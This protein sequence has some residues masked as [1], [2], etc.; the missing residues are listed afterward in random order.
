MCLDEGLGSFETATAFNNLALNISL[1]GPGK[2]L[3]IHRAGIEFAQHR[4]LVDTAMWMRGATLW[5]LFELG[6]WDELVEEGRHLLEWDESVGGGLIGVGVS[7]CIAQVSLFRGHLAE[8]RSLE[9]GF[10][11]RARHALDAQTLA[12]A[13]AIA[14]LIERATDQLPEAVRLS[15]EYGEVTR[16]DP[17]NRVWSLLRVMPVLVSAGLTQRAESLATVD[18]GA[19]CTPRHLNPLVTARA[20]LE[21]ARGNIGEASELYSQAV[22]RWTDFGFV[23][24]RGQ[25]LLGLGR[26]LVGSGR[27]D[28]GGA[29][30]EAAREVFGRLGAGPLVVETDSLLAAAASSSQ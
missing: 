7:S 12:P 25:A 17:T 27:S 30:L 24:E 20:I 28:E 16:D 18:D 8:A 29:R 10:L 21:E 13:L 26:C 14:A 5:G 23:F 1:S 2:G 15:E 6:Q 3:E 9:E 19:L 22:E 11:P 4:G